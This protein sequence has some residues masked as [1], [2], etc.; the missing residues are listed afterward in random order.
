MTLRLRL[1]LWLI[2]ALGVLLVPLGVLSVREAQRAVRSSLEQS[3]ILRLAFMQNQFIGQPVPIRRVAEVVQEYGGV[4]FIVFGGKVTPTVVGD[5][6]L[7]ANLLPSIE[8]G[9]TYRQ[10][11]GNSLWIAVP[12]EIEAGRYQAVGIRAPLGSELQALPE[13]LFTLYLTVGGVLVLLAFAVGAWGLSRSLRP[14]DVISREL[15]RRNAENLEPLPTPSLP[16]IRPAVRGVNALMSEL[17]TAF[18]QL[19]LQEQSARRFAYGAS[20]E[21]RNPL[22]AMKGY[23]EVLLRRPGEPRALEG[24]MREAGRMESLLEGLLTLARLEGRGRVQG[25]PLDLPVFL[26]ERCHLEVSGSAVVEADPA[27]LVVAVE[28]LLKNANKHAGGLEKLALEP[29][30]G[31]VWLWAYDRGP[32][33][34]PEAMPR[35]FEPF[36]KGEDSDGVGLGMA[37][38]AAVAQVMGG[39]VRAENRPEG[40]A[41]VGIW[42][43][44]EDRGKG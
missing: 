43:P 20:H 33:F 6:Q 16:E 2:L 12:G 38:V 30:A 11:I 21:L 1:F 3:L 27:M 22:A 9:I 23:L 19:K 36:F 8:Q 42:L 24:A 37:L 34:S 39:R 31:G 17:G 15:T 26:R 25:Q 41:R 32:G 40:G 13:R 10:V 4:G 44:L 14:L 7:P 28:N 29:E 18:S 35:V 5:L